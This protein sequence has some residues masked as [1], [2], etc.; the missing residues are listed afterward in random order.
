MK[1]KIFSLI[2]LCFFSLI[3]MGNDIPT[4][5][6]NEIL[7]AYFSRSGN[8]KTFAEK[9]AS[10]TGGTL[11]EIIPVEPYSDN[12]N[13]TVRR[14]REERSEEARPEFLNPMENLDGYSTIFVGFPNWGS[15]MPHVV[16]TFLEKYNLAGKNVVPF[17]TNGGGGFGNSV[18]TL[19]RLCPQSNILEG[20]Q[21][22]GSRVE[23][24]SADIERWLERIGY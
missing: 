23:S 12:Y 1:R 9:I 15:D 3:S 10:E 24:R 19:K 17:C 7:V 14:F 5:S 22:S 6:G 4:A 11:F 20:F 18:N 21:V 2:F 8:T 13:E 16:R